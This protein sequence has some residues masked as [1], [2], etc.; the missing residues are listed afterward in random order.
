[1]GLHSLATAHRSAGSFAYGSHGGWNPSA[2]D[3]ERRSRVSCL[4]S[5]LSRRIASDLVS[6]GGYATFAVPLAVST[7][8]QLFYPMSRWCLWE[9]IRAD[10]IHMSPCCRCSSATMNRTAICSVPRPVVQSC[11]GSLRCWNG[12]WREEFGMSEGQPVRSG[13]D[14]LG[15]ILLPRWWRCGRCRRLWW[16][17]WLSCRRS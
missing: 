7:P 15:A 1:M 8:R 9:S 14:A 12:G 6:S 13:C 16:A 4:E 2:S 3:N 10:P 17:R 11:F 5:C